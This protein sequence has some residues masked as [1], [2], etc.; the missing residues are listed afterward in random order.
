[1]NATLT[2]ENFHLWFRLLPD[3][4][5]GA[6]VFGGGIIVFVVIVYFLSSI[7]RYQVAI[8]AP[9]RNS[10]KWADAN[11]GRKIGGIFLKIIGLFT[12]SIFLEALWEA[13][14]YD[15]WGLDY[16]ALW[17]E[18]I[19]LALLT[20]AVFNQIAR[21]PRLIIGDEGIYTPDFVDTNA[22]ISIANVIIFCVGAVAVLQ[23]LGQD[24]TFAFAAGGIV[25]VAIALASRETAANLVCFL[26]LLLDKPFTV[27]EKILV[28]IG[29]S[30][31]ITGEVKAIGLLSSRLSTSDGIISIPNK[32]FS[33]AVVLR[34]AE[35]ENN[36]IEK[37]NTVERK[38]RTRK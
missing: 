18:S 17:I 24:V 30:K 34:M 29:E 37:E 16:V 10:E 33:D 12:V 28:F 25:S 5:K 31:D 1:M 36:E 11:T 2:A 15:F 6:F 23:E 13:F 19:P 8:T 9:L 38:P 32:V 21:L 14:L 27:G 22:I 35:K 26:A 3:T 20:V 7:W 4:A